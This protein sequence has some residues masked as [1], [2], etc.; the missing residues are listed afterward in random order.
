MVDYLVGEFM[1]SWT[2][3]KSFFLTHNCFSQGVEES[4]FSIGC[5]IGEK[6]NER[7]SKEE[8]IANTAKYTNKHIV[9]SPS[10]V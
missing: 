5:I 2:A 3:T 6:G 4:N 9:S 10:L 8:G 7:T 1:F